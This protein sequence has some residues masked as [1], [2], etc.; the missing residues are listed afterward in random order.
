MKTLH[1]LTLGTGRTMGALLIAICLMTPSHLSA[2]P[3]GGG[4]CQGG[5]GGNSGDVGGPQGQGGPSIPSDHGM[6]GMPVMGAPGTGN[7][8]DD[9]TQHKTG[10]E[11]SKKELSWEDKV[12]QSIADRIKSKLED[13][14]KEKISIPVPLPPPLLVMKE[15]YDG[16]KDGVETTKE[17]LDTIEK[18]R[19]EFKDPYTKAAQ[20]AS[21]SG[22]TGMGPDGTAN[23]TPG[24]MSPNNPSFGQGL[25][26]PQAPNEDTQLW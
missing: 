25:P 7:P 26:G 3:D 24:D 16:I 9:P 2:S 14:L 13:Y 15:T 4:S 1:S 12:L 17:V 18:I 20:G 19:Q 23:D 11:K 8:W 6:E 5:G 10:R 22:M 21:G